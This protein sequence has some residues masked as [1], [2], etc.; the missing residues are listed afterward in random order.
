[1]NDGAALPAQ[2]D[3]CP[4][5]PEQRPLREYAQLRESWFFVW[6]ANGS[7]GLLRALLFAWLLALG[8]CLLVA[9]GSIPLRHDPPRLLAAGAVAAVLLPLLLLMRQ[10]LG[11]RYVHRRLVSE[12]V[13]YEESGWYDGQ[14]WEKPLSWRQ[15]DLLVARHQVVPVLRRLGRG[16]ALA[17]GLLLLGAGF[18]QAL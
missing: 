4:V 17:G 1:M 9:S 14:V 7:L 8:P 18:C 2:T 11:W 10:W 5:P 3:P 16:M 6:P 13:E 15:Q 12:R